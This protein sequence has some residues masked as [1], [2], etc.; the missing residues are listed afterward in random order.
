MHWIPMGAAKQEAQPSPAVYSGEDSTFGDL[1]TV[2]SVHMS[3]NECTTVRTLDKC[4][5]IQAILVVVHTILY[6][7]FA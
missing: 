3:C 6:N 4:E 7:Q 2:G 1:P 5:I